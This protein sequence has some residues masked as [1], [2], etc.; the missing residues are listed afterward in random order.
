MIE[1]IKTFFEKEYA[2]CLQPLSRISYDDANDRIL[3]RSETRFFNYDKIVQRVCG[4]YTPRSPDMILFYGNNLVFIEFKAGRVDISRRRDSLRDSIKLKGVEG[5]YL[6]LLRAVRPL[7][8]SFD[9]VCSL[10]KIFIIVYN[11]SHWRNHRT[12]GLQAHQENLILKLGLGMYEGA[13]FRR[14]Q[15]LSSSNFLSW[16]GKRGFLREVE[17]PPPRNKPRAFSSEEKRKPG[18]TER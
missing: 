9:A 4:S 15:A 8:I 3:C 13:F 7:H 1:E 16:L 14:V 10:Q 12:R 5:G 11:E 2:D 17:P 6:G 18:K